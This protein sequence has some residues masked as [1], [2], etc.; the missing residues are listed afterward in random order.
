MAS[1]S[2]H[3]FPISNLFCVVAIT[4]RV[5]FCHPIITMPLRCVHNCP[6]NFETSRKA[7]LTHHQ[8]Q[9]P[10][11]SAQ[12]TAAEHLRVTRSNDKKQRI[13]ARNKLKSMVC[14]GYQCYCLLQISVPDPTFSRLT[15]RVAWTDHPPM[16]TC[17]RL[18]HLRVFNPQ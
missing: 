2:L 18:Q 15:V 4:T 7:S 10:A 9:C 8:A 12:R 6:K 14:R 5:T 1:P 16:Y 13:A 17:Q 11:Y 3:Y